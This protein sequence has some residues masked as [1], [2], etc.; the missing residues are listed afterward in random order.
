MRWNRLEH[1]PAPAI[2]RAGTSLTQLLRQPLR[3]A[4]LDRLNLGL[5]YGRGLDCRGRCDFTD[6][7]A[8]RF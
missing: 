2:P 4:I 3:A 5:W 6:A 1:M 8:G 7:R